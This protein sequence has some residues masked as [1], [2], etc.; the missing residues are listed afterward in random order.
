M[1]STSQPVSQS[2]STSQH[3][4][5]PNPIQEEEIFRVFNAQ[6]KMD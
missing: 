3:V 1:H 4:K 2:A 5:D 6:L